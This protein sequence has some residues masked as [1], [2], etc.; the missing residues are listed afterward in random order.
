MSFHISCMAKICDFAMSQLT[1]WNF[2][3]RASGI[4]RPISSTFIHVLL[5][6]LFRYEKPK[7]R[8]LFLLGLSILLFLVVDSVITICSFGFYASPFHFNSSLIHDFLFFDQPYS[9]LTSPFDFFVILSIRS[10]VLVVG[11]V[12]AARRVFH[13]CSLLFFGFQI[14]NWAFSFT[15]LLAFSENHGHQ[16][17]YVG[18]YF[19]LAWNLLAVAVVWAIWY[20]A[21]N[22]AAVKGTSYRQSPTSAE[23]REQLISDEPEPETKQEHPSRLT[24]IAHIGKILYYCKAQWQWYTVGFVFLIIFASCKLPF[25]YLTF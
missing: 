9:F 20:F 10:L 23:D 21:I 18:I 11:F 19:S 8:S 17:A 2:L 14:F 15:K 12:L 25:E 7:M 3:R 22:S 24:T 5:I 4:V 16:L 13:R 6:T 1:H